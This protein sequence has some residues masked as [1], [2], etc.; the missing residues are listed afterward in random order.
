MI[1]EESR[2]E[3]VNYAHRG[4]SE[5][6]P[7]NTMMSFGLGI[8][9]GANGIETDV[10]VTKDGIPVLF[11]D[12]T[13]ERVT[14][15]AGCIGDYTFE[16]L[17]SFRVKKNG[18][19]DRIVKFTD[20]LDQFAFRDIDFAIE[21]KQRGTAKLVVDLVRQYGIESKVTITS[22]NYAELCDVRAYAPDLTTGYLT[23]QV[24]DDLLDKMRADG[25]D[26]LCP[27]A[28]LVT[29]EAVKQWHARGFNVRAWGVSDTELM[30]QVYDAHA[31]GMTVNFPDK[32]T[33]YIKTCEDKS[34]GE[35]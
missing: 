11:H 5:Y 17:Q 10:Q 23:S 22:F 7:E 16:E 24:S 26:E 12:D 27:K 25:I 31:N 21:L 3:F 32:L 13:L 2:S 34:N 19:V 14:G 35:N 9:M 15:E 20:F 28:V 18:H 29:K 33:E 6:A 1:E 30:K 8:F 4:A